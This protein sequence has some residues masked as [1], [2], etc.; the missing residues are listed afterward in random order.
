MTHY[1]IIKFTFFCL[2]ILVGCNDESELKKERFEVYKLITNKNYSEALIKI[3]E[4]ITKNPK[5]DDYYS[6]RSQIHFQTSN[7]QDAKND[8]IYSLEINPNKPLY[9]YLY[10]ETLLKLNQLDSAQFQ[11]NKCLLLDTLFADAYKERATI[12]NILGDFDSSFVLINKAIEL[13]SE[14]AEYYNRRGIIED[15]R[16]NFSS[17][18]EDYTKAIDLRFR[19]FEV[20][21][22]RGQSLGRMNKYELAIKDL[23]ISIQIDSTNGPSYFSRGLFYYKLNQLEKACADWSYGSRLNDENCKIVILNFCNRKNI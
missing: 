9:Y 5:S 21:F 10:G 4:L 15:S 19:T 16:K 6:L 23:S 18:V 8:I 17:A 3:N 22:N 14:N 2:L 13:D 20:Y 11:F 7:F 12:L 1:K